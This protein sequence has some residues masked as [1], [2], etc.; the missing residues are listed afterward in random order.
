[1]ASLF[2]SQEREMV[3]WLGKQ[4]LPLEEWSIVISV[5]NTNILISSLLSLSH[6]NPESHRPSRGLCSHPKEP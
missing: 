6:P 4:T 2:F 3:V 1:M 5:V